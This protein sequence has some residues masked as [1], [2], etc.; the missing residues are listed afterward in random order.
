MHL[1]K[2]VPFIVVVALM[3]IAGLDSTAA[4]QIDGAVPPAEWYGDGLASVR[5]VGVDEPLATEIENAVVARIDRLDPDTVRTA[6]SIVHSRVANGDIE[7]RVGTVTAGVAE[8]ILIV[9]AEEMVTGVEVTGFPEDVSGWRARVLVK[10]GDRLIENRLLRTVYGLEEALED[11]GYLDARVNLSVEPA[12][13]NQV[14]IGFAVRAGE[15]ARVVAVEMEPPLPLDIDRT[16]LELVN[17]VGEPYRRARRREDSERIRRFLVES[18]HRQARVGQPRVER[19]DA[20]VRLHYPVDAGPHI[21][22]DFVG[23]NVTP[24]R[25]K[26]KLPALREQGFDAALIPPTSRALVNFMQSKG[27]YRARVDVDTEEGE[28]VYRVTFTLTPGERGTL[29]TLEISGHQSFE[30]KRLQS[31][32]LTE[33]GRP[34]VD[35]ELSADLDNLRSFYVRQGFAAVAIDSE[36]ESVEGRQLV[37]VSVDEGPQSTVGSVEVRGVEQVDRGEVLANLPL[38]AGHPYHESA[39]QEGAAELQRRYRERGYRSSLITAE[40]RPGADD[41]LRYEVDYSVLEGHQVHVG[42]VFLLGLDRTDP[43]FLRKVLGLHPGDVLSTDRM[44]EAESRLFQLGLFSEVDVRSSPAAPFAATEDLV[45]EVE[46]APIHRLSYGLGWDSEDGLRGL[47][48]YVRNNWLGRGLA[49]NLDTSISSREKLYRVLLTQPWVGTH[50]TPVTYSAFLFD[51][52]RESFELEQ[53]GVQVGARQQRGRTTSGLLLTWRRNEPSAGAFS[54][55]REIAPVEITSLTP[56]LFVDRRDDA[57][58]PS[59]GWSALVELERAFS[60]FDTEERFTKLF[61]QGTRYLDLGRAGTL[62]GALRVG[63]IDPISTAGE[64]PEIGLVEPGLGSADVHIS[65]RLVSGG[66]SSHRAYDRFELG[67]RGETLLLC[68]DLPDDDRDCTP[69]D[70]LPIG[71][72]ALGLVNLDWRFPIWGDLGGVAF[73]DAGNVWADWQHADRLKLGAGV[74]FR[75]ASPVGPLRLEIGWKLDRKPFED[76]YVIV[77]SVGN[78]F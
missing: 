2:G 39:V 4:A 55:D 50:R 61:I 65:E 15:R 76:P 68:E 49:W 53:A 40:A 60:L 10:A 1:R 43:A 22:I 23:F 62:A 46:E 26:G 27:Y 38:R 75:Y 73:V 13:D 33:Q 52:D 66:R 21:A 57:F 8:L 25:R 37:R 17:R 74:G 9:H 12:G 32:M 14:R 19:S 59:R 67:E 71:G 34:L 5:V 29:E 70:V 6:L 41:P 28:G 24:L 51:E 36:V 64:G 7:A 16:D 18:S 72:T 35:S 42:E 20:G 45:V 44:V 77:I 31:L 47:L 58:D 69:G 11:A 3:V 30:R 63:W 54:L 56:S 48:G 78:P